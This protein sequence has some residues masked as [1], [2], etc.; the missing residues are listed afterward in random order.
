LVQHS[1]SGWA[2]ENIIINYTEWLHKQIADGCPCALILD[3]YPTHRTDRVFA[4]AEAYD[5]ELLFVPAGGTGRFQPMDRRVFGELKARA[6]AAFD[7]RRWL[8]EGEE[9]SHDESVDI[10]IQCWNAIP[11]ENI[12]KA[13][14]VV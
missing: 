7:R 12:R 1:E 3:V 13:W 5:V 14:N 6:R 4:I 8:A 11:A 2:T 9:I 10:L